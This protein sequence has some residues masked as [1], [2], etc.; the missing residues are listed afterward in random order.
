MK[1]FIVAVAGF[2]IINHAYSQESN[3]ALI[4]GGNYTPLYEVGEQAYAEV[5]NFYLDINPVSY[6]D[7]QRFV[8][9]HPEWQKSKAKKIF[10]DSR[11][12]S[13]WENDLS[14]PSAMLDKP[15]TMISWF[16]AKAYCECQGKRLPTVD[17]WEFAAMASSSKKDAREDSLYNVSILR[18]YEQPKTYLKTIGQSPANY[19]GIKDLHGMVWEWTQDFNSIILTGESRNNGN[20]DAGLFCAAGAIGAKDMMNYAAFMRYAMRSSLK[21][22]FSITTLG[23]RCA[24]DAQPQNQMT[25]K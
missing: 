22:S 9:K 13:N 5:L 16:A 2:F 11:Y 19:W 7:F 8:Q 10:A 21:A 14:A 17:E 20:T 24:K 4:K 15:I 6:A 23:F 25:L 12:L 1:K 3:M 18:S